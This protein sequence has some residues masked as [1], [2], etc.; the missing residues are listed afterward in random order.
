[1]FWVKSLSQRSIG[2]NITSL[3]CSPPIFTSSQLK[4]PSLKLAPS[5]L[6][7][8]Y[9]D[10]LLVVRIDQPLYEPQPYDEQIF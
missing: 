7:D 9:R 4:N 3:H 10:L 1:M 6:D 5:A 2:N 8:I